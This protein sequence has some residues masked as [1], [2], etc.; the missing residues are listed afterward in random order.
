MFGIEFLPQSLDKDI[1]QLDA[2]IKGAKQYLNQE[3]D[4]VLIPANPRKCASVD[5]LL[6]ASLLRQKIKDCVFVPTLSGSGCESQSGKMRLS[7]QLLAVKY[8]NFQTLALIGGENEGMSSV[9]MMIIAREILGEKVR[10]ISGSGALDD[11]K[12]RH[13]LEQKLQA[14]ADMIITQ[15]L[16]CAKEARTFLQIFESLKQQGGYKAQ[17]FIGVFGVF[18]VHTALRINEAHL[19]FEI[20]QDYIESMDSV[21]GENTEERMEHRPKQCYERL[22]QEMEK[23]VQEY[24]AF[25]YL[26]T[27]KHNDLRAYGVRG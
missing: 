11:A 8:A 2:M 6:A 10:I 27:P 19:G 9:E 23:V 25:L 14:G 26:S 12:N 24:G 22:W 3:V 7:S 18:N 1:N 21:C 13:R 15:P 5:S 17:A 16:F 4:F 20:P